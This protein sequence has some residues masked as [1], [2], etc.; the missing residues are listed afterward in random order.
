[1]IFRKGRRN[2]DYIDET[3]SIDALDIYALYR[4]ARLSQIDSK[5]PNNERMFLNLD[6]DDIDGPVPVLYCEICS[7]K[8]VDFHLVDDDEFD[9]DSDDDEFDLNL[10]DEDEIIAEHEENAHRNGKVYRKIGDSYSYDRY[11]DDDESSDDDND[12]YIVLPE[13]LLSNGEFLHIRTRNWVD[14][15]ATAHEDS[16]LYL[17]ISRIDDISANECVIVA[18]FPDIPESKRA[19]L[20]ICAYC[21]KSISDLNNT[22]ERYIEIDIGLLRKSLDFFKNLIAD[23]NTIVL[24]LIKK[25]IFKIRGG[26]CLSFFEK[27][28]EKAT[29]RSIREYRLTEFKED[30]SAFTDEYNVSIPSEDRLYTLEID[31]DAAMYEVIK[32]ISNERIYKVSISADITGDVTRLKR[33]RDASQK[34]ATG[35]NVKNKSLVEIYSN[36]HLPADKKPYIIND[37]YIKEFRSKYPK[38][39]TEQLEALEKII[40]MDEIGTEIVLVQGPPGTGKTELIVSIAKELS[41]R[42]KNTL[43][44]SNVH[45]A[46]DNVVERVTGE[47][48]LILKRYTVTPGNEKYSDEVYENIKRYL[49]RHVLAHFEIAGNKIYGAEDYQRSIDE[50]E[51]LDSDLSV[52]DSDYLQLKNLLS[53]MTYELEQCDAEILALKQDAIAKA[54]TDSDELQT[55]LSDCSRRNTQLNNELT[56]NNFEI[57]SCTAKLGELEKEH[58]YQSDQLRFLEEKYK[59]A[60]HISSEIAALDRRLY[61]MSKITPADIPEM[62]NTIERCFVTLTLIPELG[63]NHEIIDKWNR[64]IR[65]A[66]LLEGD[67]EFWYGLNEEISIETLRKI[68]ADF[69]ETA[70]VDNEDAEMLKETLK[71]MVI[72]NN[73]SEFTKS[74][75]QFRETKEFSYDG[76]TFSYDFLQKRRK[77]LYEVAKQYRGS[78]IS[79][80]INHMKQSK[81]IELAFPNVRTEQNRIASQL[82]EQ[83]NALRDLTNEILSEHRDCNSL[84]DA[85]EKLRVRISDCES[86]I[87]ETKNKINDINEK[88]KA[89]NGQIADNNGI[90]K[91]CTEQIIDSQHKYS[92]SEIDTNEIG[93]ALAAIKKKKEEIAER[94]RVELSTY[95]EHELELLRKADQKDDRK[96]AFRRDFKH[97]DESVE[98]L[99][100]PGIDNNSRRQLLLDYIGCMSELVDT[101]ELQLVFPTGSEFFRAF[102]LESSKTGNLISMTTNQIAKANVPAFDYAIVDEA[103]KCSFEDIVTILPDIKHLV[104]I[105]DYMQLDPFYDRYDDLEEWKK[106]C[107]TVE[108]WEAF[109]RSGFSMLFDDAIKT[110]NGHGTSS[111]FTSSPYIATMKRQY[112]MNS[113]IFSLIAPIYSIHEGFELV[114]EKKQTADD[115]LCINVSDGTEARESDETS[116]YNLRE[117]ELIANTIT[118][119]AKNRDKLG[120]IESVGVITGYAAQVRYIN[121]GLRNAKLK[122]L[123]N[124]LK[125]QI[126]TFDRFQGREYDLVFVSMVRTN[127]LGFLNKIRR[128]NVALSRAK[129]KLIVLGNFDEIGR[130]PVPKG[131]DEIEQKELRFVKERLIPSLSKMSYNAGS[132][133]D[134]Y[135][136]ILHFLQQ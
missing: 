94:H 135:K 124:M 104:L 101:D 52:L 81:E 64:H 24:P 102:E 27:S 118:L 57:S 21:D 92:E 80:I 113:G 3:S 66:Q 36:H 136:K 54:K 15:K 75:M 62:Y 78:S 77:I 103:S 67:S 5:K 45:V 1:M 129:R 2:Y 46:C 70:L 119:I 91:K 117:A 55:R 73:L 69:N 26:I 87:Q 44:T 49:S 111:Y 30:L 61:Q 31:D 56:E 39:N 95:R 115:V 28:N 112:R 32:Y 50:V 84:K 34:L 125:V 48:E 65:L 114:D 97:F 90:I 11:D 93:V 131:K 109:N 100:I 134:V 110:C 38:L 22:K 23:K 4:Y 59:E 58:Q 20:D 88:N 128:M 41:A 116:S 43:V 130:M 16:Y 126:G 47:K 127:S 83:K 12:I 19:F 68:D 133:Q 13:P 98:A 132:D 51:Q 99:K 74:R 123:K 60:L 29:D 37:A 106:H 6:L 40:R 76:Y 96:A 108:S 121:D 17:D 63:L 89:I 35:T 53:E 72:Y 8:A 105:G 82:R 10:S 25:T 122:N 79:A 9:S 14:M 42:G 120:I 18:D 71:W 33:I 7:E 85:I 86:A 107:F